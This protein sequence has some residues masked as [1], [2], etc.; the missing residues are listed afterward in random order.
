MS[1]PKQIQT[2]EDLKRISD[3]V[4]INSVK[5][6]KDF[7]SDVKDFNIITGNSLNNEEKIFFIQNALIPLTNGKEFGILIHDLFEVVPE[8]LFEKYSKNIFVTDRDNCA[9]LVFENLIDKNNRLEYLNKNS[10][11]YIIEMLIKMEALKASDLNISWTRKNAILTYTING[12]SDKK[13][14]DIVPL[15]F[16]NKLKITL[17]NMSYENSSDKLID[18]KFFAEVLGVEKEFRFSCIETIAGH[19]ITIRSYEKFDIN[20]KLEDLGYLE[21]PLRIIKNIIDEN[22]YG[23]FL[24]TGK[25]GS[26]KTTTIYTILNQL[27]KELNLRIKTAEDPVELEIEG[28]DQCQINKKGEKDKWVT[29]LKLLSSFLRQRPDIIVVSEIRDKEVAMAAIEASLTGHKVMTTLHTSNVKAT[30]TR[31]MKTMDISQDRIEDSMS[32]VLSQILVDKLC[33]CK[34][35]DENGYK[36]NPNGCELCAKNKVKGIAGQIPAVEIASLKKCPE[37]FLEENFKEFYRYKDSAKE[38]FEKGLI[39]L[40]TKKYIELH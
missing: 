27:Y 34:I 9:S 37:N 15:D 4:N 2:E 5:I 8:G 32:G 19:A 35:K 21:R 1:K 11:D 13:D 18:G 24:V 3:I 12:V 17:V 38:L 20:K 31:L 40:Q 7:R 29:Y 30:F 16:A 14:E 26:G 22:P 39:D 23:I 10:S 36:R 6:I 28:I 25:T 33:D